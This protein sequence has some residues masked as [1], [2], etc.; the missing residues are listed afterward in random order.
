MV[1]APNFGVFLDFVHPFLTEVDFRF[2]KEIWRSVI[3]YGRLFLEHFTSYV[4]LST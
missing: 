3:K 1:P 2:P 4:K